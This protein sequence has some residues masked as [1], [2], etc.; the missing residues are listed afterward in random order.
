MRISE[1]H[2]SDEFGTKTKTGVRSQ[3]QHAWQMKQ[4]ECDSAQMVVNVHG[5]MQKGNIAT[6]PS[7]TNVGDIMVDE[8][9]R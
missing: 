4:L 7:D 6:I 2:K 3:D 5:F 9:W 8:I 1:R